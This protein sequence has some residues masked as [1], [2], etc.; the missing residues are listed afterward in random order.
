MLRGQEAVRDLY[1]QLNVLNGH[2]LPV[3]ASCKRGDFQGEVGYYW[4][5]FVV[6]ERIRFE[7]E[8]LQVRSG[9][10][11]T[12]VKLAQAHV[13]LQNM[14]AAIAHRTRVIESESRELAELSQTECLRS[15]AVATID[16]AIGPGCLSG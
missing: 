3:I 2:Q 5:F 12:A 1:L 10:Q 14:H 16:P 4:V 11:D 7:A 13:G 6:Q 9:A 15:G 8:L